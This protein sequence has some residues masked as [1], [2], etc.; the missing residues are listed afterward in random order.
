MVRLH[1]ALR[2]VLGTLVIT[3]TPL[4]AAAPSVRAAH[5]LTGR[6]AAAPAVTDAA[7]LA[8]RPYLALAYQ[9]LDR[10]RARYAGLGPLSRSATLSA[11]AEAHSAYMEAIGSWSDGD[12][13]GSILWRVH[14]AGLVNAVYAGQ[15]VVTATSATMDGAIRQGEAFF[16][17][18]AAGGGPHWDN[19]TNPNHHSVGMGVA[20]LGGP[21]NYTIYLT[22]VFADQ[23]FC[24]A[25]QS[26]DFSQ[27]GVTT[28]ALRVGDVAHPSVD[29]LQLRS[30]PHGMVIG[31]VHGRDR[32]KIL[33]L[34]GE[35][36]QVKVLSSG[37]F[38]WVFA[39]FLTRA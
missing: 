15:N 12:P 17:A 39:P 23:G 26:A 38:G 20:L 18:E 37:L 36:A 29:D 14:A 16:A 21:G 22:Q 1:G 6:C 3:A 35:W 34:Q 32:L 13:N 2:A 31:M 27:A 9:A 33:D 10:D 11:V 19:I 25:V 8:G 5:T 30:Q 24:G 7:V 28:S 4:L